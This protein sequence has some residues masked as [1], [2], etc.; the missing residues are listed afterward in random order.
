[1]ASGV[2]SSVNSLSYIHLQ[3]ICEPSTNS[4]TRDYTD[5]DVQTDN[6]AYVRCNRADS[7]LFP[8]VQL[9]SRRCS[10]FLY[11]ARRKILPLLQSGSISYSLPGFRYAPPWAN[12]YRHSVAR[13]HCKGVI[14]TFIPICNS[15]RLLQNS[16]GAKVCAR[17]QPAGQREPRGDDF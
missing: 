10:H 6:A 16:F 4:D 9:S 7:L 3:P 14:E 1:V 17:L 11:P 15:D 12:V 5:T 2:Y 13:I 8:L